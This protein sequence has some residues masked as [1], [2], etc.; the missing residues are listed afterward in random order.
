MPE[1]IALLLLPLLLA[2]AVVCGHALAADA[3]ISVSTDKPYYA[4]GDDINFEIFVNS[5]DGAA[6]GDLVLEVFPADS[7]SSSDPFAGDP[8]SSQVI[9]AGYSLEGEDTVSYKTDTAGLDLGQGGYP[10]RVVIREG[11]EVRAA[12]TTWIAV[13]QEGERDPMDLV[14][15]WTV[16]NLPE[17]NPQ[18]EFTSTDLVDRCRSELDRPDN[19]LQHEMAA[20]AFPAIKTVYAME[21]MLLDQLQDLSDGFQLRQGDELVDYPATSTESSTAAACLESLGNAAA[22]ENTEVL[23]Y[24]YAFTQL[25]LLAREGWSD[26]S[27][28]YRVGDDVLTKALMLSAEPAGSYVPML[29]LTTDSLRYIAATGGEYAVIAGAIRADVQGIVEEDAVSF[30]LRDVSGERITSF[31]ADDAASSALLGSEPDVNGFF[32]ALANAY[33]SGEPLVIAAAATQSPALP[34]DDRE[35]VYAVLTD[36]QWLDSITMVE[37]RDK[38]RP[39]TQPVTLLRYVDPASR[40]ITQAYYRRL[41]A[42]HVRYDDLRIALDTHEPVLQRLDRLLFTA[43]GSYWAGDYADPAEANRGLVYLEEVDRI[44]DNEFSSL[45]IDVDTPWL[46]RTMSGTALIRIENSSSHPFTVDFS[47]EGEGVELIGGYE[48]PLRLDPGTTEIEIPFVTDGW[49]NLRAGIGSGG[50]VIAEES[51]VIH[52]VSGRVWVVILVA[53]AALAA[54]IAYYFTVIRRAGER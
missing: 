15:L 50:T 52:P 10:A 29:D 22:L 2:A 18:G 9:Q 45:E 21:P 25:P 30:R 48:S 7:V 42:T 28:Q 36:A 3:V 11:D 34:A 33:S 17:R 5:G 49:R 51:A 38:Y 20:S 1:K 4:P 32:A 53:L 6:V 24:P 43:E 37:A 19:L 8:L 44:T 39:D 47:L 31:F 14:L 12:G 27:S 13:I 26:G 41:S 35:A 54:G 23:S 16:G 40:Y 46:Q